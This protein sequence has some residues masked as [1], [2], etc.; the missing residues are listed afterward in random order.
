MIDH[1]PKC[2]FCRQTALRY[3]VH[4]GIAICRS[5]A[6]DVLPKVVADALFSE[7][8]YGGGDPRSIIPGDLDH[9]ERE[10]YRAMDQNLSWLVSKLRAEA[11]K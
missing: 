1:L 6:V 2:V 7:I 11:K 9:F 5:C 4:N 8:Q 10:F 3:G